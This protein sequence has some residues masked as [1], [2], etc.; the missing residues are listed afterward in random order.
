MA[1]IQRYVSK[2]LTHFIGRN[3]NEAKQYDL[4]IEILRSRWLTHPPHNPSISGNLSINSSANLQEMYSPEVV[5]FCDIPVDDIDIHMS[6]GSRFGISLLKKFLVEKGANP[7]FYLSKNSIVET[8]RNLTNPEEIRELR[9]LQ[10]RIGHEAIFNHLSREEYFEIMIKNYHEF[11]RFLETKIR[12]F[13][14]AVGVSEEEKQLREL[15]RFF[16]FHIFSFIKLFDDSLPDNDP[17]NYYMER[18]WRLL[19]NFKFSLDNVVRVI[20][21]QKFAQQ[22]RNDIPDYVGQITFSDE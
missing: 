8:L 22:F 7:V 21:P 12:E 14:D 4:L 19:G 20:L 6:K 10:E 1:K 18:E 16:D 9:E 2:E 5:C 15:Q 11:F 3:L 17:E 13:S